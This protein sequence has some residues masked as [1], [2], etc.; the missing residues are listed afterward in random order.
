MEHRDWA[1]ATELHPQLFVPD[2]P[3]H[4]QRDEAEEYLDAAMNV[5]SWALVM[6]YGD[7]QLIIT[8]TPNDITSALDR[9]SDLVHATNK[10]TNR[11]TSGY[12]SAQRF[13]GPDARAALGFIAEEIAALRRDFPRLPPQVETRIARIEQLA[14]RPDHRSPSDP[15]GM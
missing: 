14:R 9:A 13:Y 8:G 1:P 5:P 12:Q 11:F 15:A 7:G 6:G 4:P 10:T 3:G 2:H